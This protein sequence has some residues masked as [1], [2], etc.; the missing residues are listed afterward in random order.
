MVLSYWYPF[1]WCRVQMSKKKKKNIKNRK[2]KQKINNNNFQLRFQNIAF[3]FIFVHVIFRILGTS[4][5]NF[6]NKGNTF[7]INNLQKD[8]DL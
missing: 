3:D 1:H 7:C 6:E 2:L 4:F 8:N 5:Y